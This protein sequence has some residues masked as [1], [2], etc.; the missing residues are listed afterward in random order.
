MDY[1]APVTGKSMDNLYSMQ[2]KPAE[3]HPLVD[4]KTAGK[5]SFEKSE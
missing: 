2:P 5:E 1:D 3:R 4:S